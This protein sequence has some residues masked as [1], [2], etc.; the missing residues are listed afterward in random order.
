MRRA[1]SR[2]S[3]LY[4]RVVLSCLSRGRRELFAEGDGAS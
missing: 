4:L 1:A 3:E 2:V